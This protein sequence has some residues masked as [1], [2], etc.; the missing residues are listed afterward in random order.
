MSA[1]AVMV[2]LGLIL[3]GV[4]VIASRKLF[5]YE[6]PRINVV[7]T[8]LP[9]SNCGACGKP[10]C[11]AFAEQAV[12]GGVSPGQCTVSSE[13][14]RDRIAEYLGVDVGGNEKQVARLACAGGSNVA[15]QRARYD[16]VSTCQLADLVA[17]GGK[18]CPWGCLGF[19]DCMEVCDFDAITMNAH[20]LPVVNA[21]LC[22]ACGDCVE[23]CPRNLFELHAVSHRLWVACKN[24]ALA[25][26]AESE[27]AVACNG[28]GRCAADAPQGLI[29]MVDNLAV[30]DYAHN[31]LAS[32]GAIQR[33]P[34]GAI[35]WLRDG[36]EAMKGPQ[37]KPVVR[38]HALPVG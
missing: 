7:E 6:D 12:S 33:C 30:V 15:R 9:G 17:G 24:L 10:G 37:A 16:G 27:C 18:G 34:T 36:T 5:V 23:I 25:E 22:T 1:L 14:A 13:E 32:T 20:S 35:V 8:M 21:E 29:R 28:C 4:L 19:G 31:E 26:E 2:A 38:H 11:R 3:A